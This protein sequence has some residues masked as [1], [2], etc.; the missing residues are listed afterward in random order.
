MTPFSWSS[1]A[2]IC[3]CLGKEA[4]LWLIIRPYI[5]L[6]HITYFALILMFCFYLGLIQPLASSLFTCECGHGLKAFSMHLTSCL[7]KGQWITTHDAIKKSCMHL[8]ERV[9]TLYG[10]SDDTP[11]V[12][13]FITN[14]FLHDSWRP[15]LC[16]RCGG[17]WPNTEDDGYECHY[18]TKRWSCKI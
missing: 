12:R 3:S 14:Q 11:Y 1:R 9:A 16:C 8:L 13:S 15:G 6:F 17:Y 7:F 2:H 10:E 4:G 5:H 18:L